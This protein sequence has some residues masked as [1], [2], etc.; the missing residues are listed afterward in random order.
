M[1][2]AVQLLAVSDLQLLKAFCV[3]EH[4]S[5][6]SPLCCSAGLRICDI[7]FSVVCKLRCPVPALQC[8]RHVRFALSNG[9]LDLFKL[10]WTG[11]HDS[12]EVGL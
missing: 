8:D 10:L 6:H 2:D 7:H 4:T 9:N 11:K 5:I 1:Q 12:Q 3:L